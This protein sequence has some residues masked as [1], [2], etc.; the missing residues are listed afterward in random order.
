VRHQV[1][2]SSLVEAGAEDGD[3]TTRIHTDGFRLVHRVELPAPAS[4]RVR[5]REER[6]QELSPRSCDEE[7]ARLEVPR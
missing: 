6:L 3:S 4:L 2:R 5:L 7:C 1:S